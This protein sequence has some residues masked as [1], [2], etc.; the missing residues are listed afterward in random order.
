[1]W[2][3]KFGFAVGLAVSLAIA[4]VIVSFVYEL[5]L[6]DP[7]GVA[8]S[9]FVRLPVILLVGFLTD[10]VPRA[11]RRSRG[12]HG[13]GEHF[14]AVVRERW[15]MEHVRYALIGLGS[16]YLTYA[17]FRNLKSFV[18]FVNPGDY[19]AQLDRIDR[20][21]FLGHDPA[22]VLHSLMGTGFAASFMSLIYI[23]WI[24][25]VP[26]ALA[27]ALVFSRNV[28]G[29]SWYVTA[30]VV[31]WVLGAVSY[32][33]LPTVGPIY[34]RPE[35]FDDLRHT[36]STT[37]Q[38]LMWDERL[39]VI[40]DPFAT[41]ALQTIAAFA[42][43]HVGIMVTTCLIAHLLRLNVWVRAALWIFL[44]L[45]VLSTVYLGWHYVLDA[46]G[47][48]ALGAVAVVIGAVATGNRLRRGRVE[49]DQA[50]TPAT[51]PAALAD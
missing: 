2:K 15:P 6:R 48:F 46:F 27:A 20:A 13:F 45:T 39:E 42:S 43:L 41:E 19:D 21:L 26:A 17:A 14:R 12:I 44:F 38:D 47:G 31:D 35:M 49:P 36:W 11:F 30:V 32:F 5:P 29:G 7:D 22:E 28:A 10:V 37:L 16:W 33:A 25:F 50:L 9:T 51:V 40:A 8:G 24:V 4:A 34:A 1:V 3:Q 18:P 23:A